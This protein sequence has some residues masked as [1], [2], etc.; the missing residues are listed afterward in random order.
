[1][2][3]LW[4]REGAAQQTATRSGRGRWVEPWVKALLLFGK[5]NS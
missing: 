3:L 5:V 1:M 4:Y 2:L